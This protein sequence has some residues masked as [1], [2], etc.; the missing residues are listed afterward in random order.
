METSS[1]SFF[2]HTCAVFGTRQQADCGR[3]F[4]NKTSYAF[5]YPRFSE[6][7]ISKI[8]NLWGS[9]F[10]ENLQNLIY[11]LKMDE[12][13]SGKILVFKI[14]AFELVV[15]F[16]VIMVRIIV[17]ISS[18]GKQCFNMQSWDLKSDYKGSFPA[19]SKWN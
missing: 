9:N 8:L 19:L 12:N 16:S 2:L 14:S 5:K 7:I 1:K 11:I 13:I 17:R 4:W 18:I 6:W 3:M 15:V 10:F